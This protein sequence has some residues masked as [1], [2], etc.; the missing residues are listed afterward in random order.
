MSLICHCTIHIDSRTF[1]ASFVNLLVPR[2]V[3]WIFPFLELTV[4]F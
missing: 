4:L 2:Y 3:D 1:I